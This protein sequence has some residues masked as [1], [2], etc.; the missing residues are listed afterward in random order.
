MA[1]GG[2]DRRIEI[3]AVAL[4]GGGGAQLQKMIVFRRD[5]H[6]VAR[7]KK[8]LLPFHVVVGIPLH[9]IKQLVT[10]VRVAVVGRL[11]GRLRPAVGERAVP[12]LEQKRQKNPLLSSFLHDSKKE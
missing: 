7:V 11:H 4:I 10:Q 5:E 9:K 12:V 1:F 2:E 6:Q 8:K 3:H